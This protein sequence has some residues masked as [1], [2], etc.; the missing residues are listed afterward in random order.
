ML[1]LD[2]YRSAANVF[3]MPSFMHT[4][5]RENGTYLNT[6][7]FET[8]KVTSHNAIFA[9]VLHTDP[10]D[11][12]VSSNMKYQATICYDM[13]YLRL[14]AG[15]VEYELLRKV[16]HSILQCEVTLLGFSSFE[17]AAGLYGKLLD[18]LFPQRD[19]E[20]NEF[21]CL[22]RRETSSMVDMHLHLVI[23]CFVQRREKFT[24]AACQCAVKQFWCQFFDDAKHLY[25]YHN[26]VMLVVGAPRRD[27]YSVANVEAA[28][29][30]VTSTKTSTLTA[31]ELATMRA[32][33]SLLRLLL[34]AYK[35]R[36]K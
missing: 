13:R 35:Y 19:A 10:D 31:E 8:E 27:G 23:T 5:M 30:D 16:L 28:L 6:L 29:S 12:W 34:K 20:D 4:I 2:E 24:A 21:C 25:W 32:K 15:S 1:F 36:V 11:A 9:V 14:H 26:Y 22:F 3:S 7:L 17:R 18:I 33:Q